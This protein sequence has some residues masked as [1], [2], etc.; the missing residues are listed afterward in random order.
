MLLSL[1]KCNKQSMNFRSILCQFRNFS[2][3]N[4]ANAKN[5][6]VREVSHP[7]WVRAEVIEYTNAAGQKSTWERCSRRSS[8]EGRCDSVGI[9]A[10]L[11]KLTGDELVVLRQFR[12][13]VG[14]VCI[15]VPAGLL[16]PNET[17]EQCAER[18]L[19]EETGLIGKAG[20]TGPIM[21]NDPGFSNTSHCFVQVHVD[22]GDQ[23][24]LNPVQKL[25]FNE[26]I[27]VFTIPLLQLPEKLAGL[28]DAGYKL[29]GRLACIAQGIKLIR[30]FSKQV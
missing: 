5:W 26:F 23:R 8:V 13:P 14:G 6:S 12:P 20:G 9:I 7:K 17:I 22:S 15:E 11:K 10:I 19:R 4:L 30:S 28:A 25:E 29:D 2:S 18:E 3:W 27:D 21:F 24:N 1:A 16:D